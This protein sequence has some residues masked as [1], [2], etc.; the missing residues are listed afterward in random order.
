ME[1]KERPHVFLEWG[2]T[3]VT[4]SRKVEW[5][6]TTRQITDWKRAGIMQYPMGVGKILCNQYLALVFLCN[7]SP[8]DQRSSLL[9]DSQ[10]RFGGLYLKTALNR[11]A[12]LQHLCIWPPRCA[13]D[14][15]PLQTGR[16]RFGIIIL[17]ING[18]NVRVQATL[19][20]LNQNPQIILTRLLRL[21]Q[22]MSPIFSL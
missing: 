1:G 13:A 12:T 15:H 22:S 4:V 14:D 16:G 10:L 11:P 3:N 21:P 20:S 5:L 17:W 9:V 18:S 19:I 8:S 2:G 7:I 6:G